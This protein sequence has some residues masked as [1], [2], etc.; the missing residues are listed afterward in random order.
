MSKSMLVMDT[1]ENCVKCSLYHYPSCRCYV[2]SRIQNN[3]SDDYKPD[4]CPLQEVPKKKPYNGE[5]G[6]TGIS[7]SRKVNEA[8]HEAAA[9][10]WNACIDEIL[11]ECE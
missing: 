4:W 2:T 10:G 1:P 8:L 3:I 9:L 7:L 11:K 6:I 5:D